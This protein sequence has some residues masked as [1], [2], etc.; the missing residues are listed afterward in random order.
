MHPLTA[1]SLNNLALLYQN[2]GKY[3]QAE[4]LLQQALTIRE[5]ALGPTHHNTALSV[6]CLAFGYRQQQEYEKA[7]PLYRRAY[8]IYEQ[9]LGSEH[10][11]MQNLRQQYVSLLRAMGR[12]GDARAL[13]AGDGTNKNEQY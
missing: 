2:Q 8:S 5:Q 1:A 10:P 11:D 4:S 6:W 7:E 9:V 3:T 13:E 12:E